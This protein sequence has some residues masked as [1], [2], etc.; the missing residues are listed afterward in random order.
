MWTYSERAVLSH[1]QTFS[2]LTDIG[3]ISSLKYPLRLGHLRVRLPI[4]V[5]LAEADS[6][7]A[8]HE[9]GTYALNR[10]V[11]PRHSVPKGPPLRKWE[12]DRR[13]ASLPPLRQNS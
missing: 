1:Q 12:W 3:T 10:P 11:A 6:L 9:D 7:P 13:C 2:D 4:R 8:R 5:R